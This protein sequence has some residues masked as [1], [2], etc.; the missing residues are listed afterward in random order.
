MG[1]M[2]VATVLVMVLAGFAAVPAGAGD[3]EVQVIVLFDD[4]V[5]KK[6]IKD[7]GG[8]IVREYD[9]IPGVVVTI[10]SGKIK[11]LEKKDKVDSVAIDA[12]V[13]IG[14]KPPKP[15]KPDKD[16]PEQ[17][18]QEVPWGIGQ[19]D[20]D[21]VTLTGSGVKVAIVDTGIDKD[22]PDLT[23][24][25]GVNLINTRKSYDDDNGHGTHCAGIIGALDNDI[26][27]VGVAPGVS[28][29]AVKVLDRRG[30]GYYSTIIAGIEWAISNEMNVISMSLSGSSDVQA[31]EDAC[32]AARLADI[33]VVA[34][35]GNDNHLW[36]HYPAAY[37]SVISVGATDDTNTIAWWSN[38]GVGL[39]VVAPGV[40]ILSTY[41]GGEY[42]ELSG[43]SMACPHV[44]GTAALIIENSGSWSPEGVQSILENTATDLG[45]PLYDTTYGWGLI[46]ADAATT[47]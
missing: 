6:A 21:E 47:S 28:L 23:V 25:G 39:D 34:A 9:Y 29:Y 38:E 8:K 35:S 16:P 30:S 19:I 5:D 44:A 31:L 32:D 7:I 43:T 4:E 18:P 41:K 17:P 26:G 15:G 3:K 45:T 46:Q 24:A 40:E 36:I 42:K 20:A 37:D 14:V 2:S 12:K 13:T 10:S 1:V 22:H 33:V 11:A 27:V